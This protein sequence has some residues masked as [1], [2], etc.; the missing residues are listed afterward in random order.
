ML[1]K[2]KDRIGNGLSKAGKLIDSFA[3]WTA[4]LGVV[5]RW[6]GAL[7]TTLWVPSPWLIWSGKLTTLIGGTALWLG[8]VLQRTGEKLS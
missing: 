5:A 4:T 1:K 7:L 3:P 8:K 6:T 2:A